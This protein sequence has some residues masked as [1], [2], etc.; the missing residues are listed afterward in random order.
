MV[1]QHRTPVAQSLPCR[2]AGA[3]VSSSVERG[4]ARRFH[5]LEFEWNQ[6]GSGVVRATTMGSLL[7]T[8]AQPAA[9]SKGLQR[10][11]FEQ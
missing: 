6:H 8:A 9:S 3:R 4:V 5:S 2:L 11:R 1:C 7:A 10:K